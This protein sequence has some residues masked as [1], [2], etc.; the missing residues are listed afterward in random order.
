MKEETVCDK[1]DDKRKGEVSMKRMLSFTLGAAMV[2]SL[3]ACGGK[4]GNPASETKAQGAG[5]DTAG[6]VSA[7]SGLETEITSTDPVTIRLAYDVAESHPSH[8]AFVEKFQNA[9]QNASNGNITVEL[10]PNSQLG[11]LAENMEAMRIGDLEM[12]ALNDSIVAGIV[13]E[14]NLVGLPLDIPGCSS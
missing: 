5:T 12:A 3:A 1:N 4:G 14:Y 6:A 8:K 13:P 10:Y 11:S 9:L 7:D 2:L